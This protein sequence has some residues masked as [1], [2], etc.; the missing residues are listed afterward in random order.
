MKLALKVFNRFLRS[1]RTI[2]RNPE[3]VK[4]VFD[5]VDGKVES[6]EGPLGQILVKTRLAGRMITDFVSGRYKEV[7]A[8][9]IVVLVG[10][11]LYILSPLDAVVDFI[12]F[13]GYMDDIFIFNLVY[14]QISKDLSK[15]LD[16]AQ[17]NK[18]ELEIN[19][20]EVIEANDIKELDSET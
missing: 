12:P 18:V 11:G 2:S 15:Y 14:S 16:W 7:P 9:T 8:R 19:K 10:A 17:K 13:A 4:A 3:K 20:S 6:N 5:K 1:A